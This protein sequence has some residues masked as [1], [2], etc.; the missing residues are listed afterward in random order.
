V[1]KFISNINWVAIPLLFAAKIDDFISDFNVLWGKMGAADLLVTPCSVP[2]PGG[3]LLGN[4]DEMAVS[5]MM[6]GTEGN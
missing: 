2:K 3:H 4:A 1:E 6:R 5:A